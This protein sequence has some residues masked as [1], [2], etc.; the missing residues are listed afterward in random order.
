MHADAHLS[1]RLHAYHLM[2]AAQGDDH[3]HVL[4][5]L[6]ALEADAL[7]RGWADAALLAACGRFIHALV[8]E[9]DRAAVR[10]LADELVRR[11]RALQDRAL[12]GVALA[13]RAVVSAETGDHAGVLADAGR[14]VALV[15]PDDLDPM[16]RCFAWVVCGAA[17]NVLNLWELTDELYDRA[18]AT[19]P[20]CAEA[21]Q[22]PAIAV[23]RV[24]V[25]LEWTAA[26]LELGDDEEAAVQLRRAAEAV[27]AAGRAD[28]VPALWAAEIAAARDLLDFVG[29]ALEDGPAATAGR[30]SLDVLDRHR[31]ALKQAGSVE[32]GPLLAGLTAVALLRVGRPDQAAVWA[33]DP[34][35]LSSTSGSRS[36]LAWVRA[37]V[38][39]SGCDL[40]A[41]GP[42]RDYGALVGRLRW[43][44]RTGVL[45]AA[46]SKIDDER[47]SVEHAVLSRDVLLDPLTGVANRRRFDD[48]LVDVPSDDLATALIVIDIDYFKLVNDVHGHAVGDEALRRVA[49]VLTDHVR[50]DDLALRLGGDEFALLIAGGDD[51]AAIH[52]TALLRAQA[53]REA[54]ADVDWDQLSPGLT[55]RVSVG[56][57]ALVVGPLRSDAADRLYR[58]ADAD[59]YDAKAARLF[60]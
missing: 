51:V 60:R 16:D 2:E 37:E 21:V 59:L 29:R 52:H 25:R 3:E 22:E 45:A 18:S 46:R 14:A 27:A 39:S 35:V 12:L 32:V 33:G 47:L 57:A 42:A 30:A 15:G 54:V 44:A 36:F 7:A 10:C 31:H 13:L 48:W 6:L 43:N 11:A 49:R 28:N 34:E 41:L 53:I 19:A 55:V 8:R 20:L 17:Y 38:A 1:A 56:V 9:P 24:I 5:D 4:G 50:A 23:S 26:L 58:A 40:P